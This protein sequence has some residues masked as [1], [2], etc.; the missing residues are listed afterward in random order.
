MADILL[1][2]KARLES[3]RRPNSSFFF[4][5]STFFSDSNPG[6]SKSQV[7]VRAFR[8]ASFVPSQVESLSSIYSPSLLSLLV[9]KSAPSLLSHYLPLLALLSFTI[10]TPLLSIALQTQGHLCLRPTSIYLL[11]S[12]FKTNMASQ[13]PSSR[14]IYQLAKKTRPSK[15]VVRSQAGR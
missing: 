2:Y 6:R 5:I 4:T 14:D 3:T 11:L 9:S 12:H 15:I 8:I 7:I 13:V 1:T 10:S